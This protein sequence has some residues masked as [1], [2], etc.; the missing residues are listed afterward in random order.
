MGSNKVR[1][2]ERGSHELNEFAQSREW[3]RVMFETR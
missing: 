1:E 3:K 2:S